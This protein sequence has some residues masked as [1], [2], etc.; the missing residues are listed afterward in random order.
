LQ[1]VVFR[2]IT[3]TDKRMLDVSDLDLPDPHNKFGSVGLNGDVV[4]AEDW[5]HSMA[6]FERMLLQKLYPQFP[7]SR[8]LA[9]RLKTSHSMIA[10]K[11]RKYGI[12]GHRGD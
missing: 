5:E 11:L 12:P 8:K 4:P 3:M 9:Q 2:A 10:N 1:N 7:S 6:G